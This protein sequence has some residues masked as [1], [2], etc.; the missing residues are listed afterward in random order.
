MSVRVKE[1]YGMSD[2]PK[3]NFDGLT[4]ETNSVPLGLPF[5]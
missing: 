5:D 2:A 4:F 3:A 1:F